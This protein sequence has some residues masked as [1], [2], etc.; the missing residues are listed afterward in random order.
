MD[1][2][3]EKY[4]TAGHRTYGYVRRYVQI[5]ATVAAVGMAIYTMARLIVERTADAAVLLGCALVL[6][7]INADRKGKPKTDRRTDK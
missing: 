6:S 1:D 2:R 4:E 5:A 3:A 7:L